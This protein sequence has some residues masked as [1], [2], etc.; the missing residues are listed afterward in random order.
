MLTIKK[1]FNGSEIVKDKIIKDN[2]N[3]KNGLFSPLP[4]QKPKIKDKQGN[5]YTGEF[6]N[7]KPIGLFMID[8][9]KGGAYFGKVN[10][11]LQPHGEGTMT[12]MYGDVI[13]RGVFENGKL[14]LDKIPEASE[15]SEGE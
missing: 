4:E 14:V 3:L 6:K 8:F 11:R 12:D 1:C 2:L 9:K 10:Q 13:K 7:G 15:L 5:V